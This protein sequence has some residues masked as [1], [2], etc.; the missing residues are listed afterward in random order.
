MDARVSPRKSESR[1]GFVSF[2]PGLAKAAETKVIRSRAGLSLA[3]AAGNIAAAVLVRAKERTAA[4]HAL[5]HARFARVEAICWALGIH[6]SLAARRERYIVVGTVPIR[7]PLPDVARHVRQ[8]VSV[9]W[10][11]SDR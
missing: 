8:S 7:G 10:K 1:A 11:R 4:Q 3:A 5:P 6:C 9:R 2:A